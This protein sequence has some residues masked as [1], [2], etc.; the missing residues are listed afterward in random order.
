MNNYTPKHI[1][2]TGGAGFI[3]CNFIRHLLQSDPTIFI[4]NLDKLTYAGSFVNLQ[5]LPDPHRYVFVQGDIG[6][7]SLVNELLHKYTIDT[8]VHFA[9]ESHVDRSIHSPRQFL[10]TNITG[11]FT[12]LEAACRYW[13]DKNGL[14]VQACRFH[15]ISTDEVYGSLG[16]HDPAFT[17][18]SVYAP[19]SPYSASKAASDHLVR[20]Y[21]HTYHLPTT[22][23]HCSNNY[24]PYQHS[25]KFIPTVI[26][27]CLKQKP[28]PVYGNGSNIRDWIHVMDHCIGIEQ[29]LRKGTAGEKYNL[30]G[31]CE[32]ANLAVVD[33]I[34]N[35]F[36]QLYPECQPHNKLIHYVT[37]RPG[38][39]WRYAINS[40][41]AQHELGWQLRYSFQDGIRDT[42]KW[43][44]ANQA[45]AGEV[46]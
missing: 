3:G 42:V 9:A 25:E 43:F 32:L 10:Q 27:S 37:D 11:T 46:I 14:S 4:L 15:H 23:T 33:Y 22:I 5:N 2:V 29:V 39:D 40:S 35:Y 28:I 1:L 31:N 7:E 13:K 21:Q 45:T 20:S 34:T 16:P 44:I 19:N 41:K 8:V 17:E 38:H 12:L 6:D 26:A 18:S 36:D 24:G 30:G